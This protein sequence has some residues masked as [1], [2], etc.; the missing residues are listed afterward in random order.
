MLEDL[1]DTVNQLNQDLSKSR[2]E[3]LQLVR[4]GEYIAIYVYD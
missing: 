2:E 1:N 4:A 3:N